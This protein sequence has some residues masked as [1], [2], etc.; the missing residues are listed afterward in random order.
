MWMRSIAVTISV[1]AASAQTLDRTK[2]PQTPPIPGYK[3][4]PVFETIEREVTGQRQVADAEVRLVRV[5]IDD[6]RVVRRSQVS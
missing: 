4:P 1:L 3:L 5:G 2:P 6:E